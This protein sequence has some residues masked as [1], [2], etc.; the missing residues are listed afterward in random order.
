M[1]SKFLTDSSFTKM[2]CVSDWGRLDQDAAVFAFNPWGLVPN[3]AGSLAYFYANTVGSVR[4]GT[5]AANKLALEGFRDQLIELVSS[6]VGSVDVASLMQGA[7]SKSNELVNIFSKEMGGNDRV[8]VGCIA[9]IIRHGVAVVGRNGIGGAVLQ[10]GERCFNFE[11]KEGSS[12][13]V[14][15]LGRDDH[16]Q[17]D[18]VSVALNPGDLIGIGVSNHKVPSIQRILS[19]DLSK[20]GICVSVG[21]RS[22]FV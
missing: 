2:D 19:T 1:K 13:S 20:G 14:V 9:L 6:H 7:L 15:P 4:V 5:R 10:R 11:S 18:I 3:G 21:A 22:I 17:G 12:V 8:L 16:F